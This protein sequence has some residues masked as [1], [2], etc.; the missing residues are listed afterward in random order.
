MLTR[1]R[2]FYKRSTPTGNM[3]RTSLRPPRITPAPPPSLTPSDSAASSPH[4]VPGSG[5]RRSFFRTAVFR[6]STQEQ[7]AAV[8]RVGAAALAGGVFGV[9]G[10]LCFFLAFGTDYWLVA[11]DNCGS[12]ATPTPPTVDKDANKTEVRRESGERSWLKWD[13]RNLICVCVHNTLRC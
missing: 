1:N 12:Y 10:T 11:S 8:M 5:W 6:S 13:V 9:V 4:G 3:N 7:Q 2:S